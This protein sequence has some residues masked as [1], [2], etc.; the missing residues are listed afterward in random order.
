[1]AWGLNQIS[2]PTPAFA[3]WLFRIVLYVANLGNLAIISFTNMPDHT[4]ITIVAVSSFVT[5]AVHSA[6]KMFGVPL[7]AGTEIQKEEVASLK[8]DKPDVK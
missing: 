4:K 8:V 6:S 3:T 5:L 1:M 7:P 2:N